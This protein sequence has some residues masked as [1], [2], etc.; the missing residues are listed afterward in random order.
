MKSAIDR[1]L[2]SNKT[3]FSILLFCLFFPLFLHGNHFGLLPWVKGGDEPHY[4]T[5]IN[6]FLN[7]GDFDLRNQYEAALHG[8]FDAGRK[9]AGQ[10]IGRH[11]EWKGMK[12]GWPDVYEEPDQWPLDSKGHPVPTQKKG[13]QGDFSNLPEYPAHPV[14][15]AFLLAPFL[16]FVRGTAY[17]EPLALFFSFLAVAGAAY[18]FRW[19]VRRY[20]RGPVAANAAM[21]LVFLA[22]PVWMNART[23]FMEPFL[24]FFAM[25]AYCSFVKTRSGFWTGLLLGLGGLLKPNFL[26][27]VLPPIFFLVQE[28]KWKDLILIAIGPALATAFFLTVND[29]FYGSPFTPPQLVTLGRPLY[30]AYYLLFSWNHG[31]FLFSPIALYCLWA[32]KAHSLK[33]RNESLLLGSGFVLYF[34]FMVFCWAGP[35]GWSFGP[36]H[37]VPVIPFLMIPMVYLWADYGKMG[38]IRKGLVLAAIGISIFINFFGALDGYWDSNPVTLL[39]G[40]IAP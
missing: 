8:S 3:T 13:V 29:L 14:G 17:V 12:I 10:P 7:D 1:T 31:L 19:L 40:H 35:W 26:V 20:E 15:I 5:I 27:L 36:R 18:L 9:Y 21:L 6:S 4:L 37:I 30:E 23:L 38:R 24:L 34:L 25:A 28:R 2:S 32:W 39:G 11:I 33:W 16:W 22:S